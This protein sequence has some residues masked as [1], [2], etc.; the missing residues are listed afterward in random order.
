[1]VY[2][3]LTWRL[4]L[5]HNFHLLSNTFFLSCIW[6]KPGD[7]FAFANSFGACYYF[8]TYCTFFIICAEVCP[9]A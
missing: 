6:L 1:M 9:G 4:K 3:I 2:L 8:G 5:L 7:K